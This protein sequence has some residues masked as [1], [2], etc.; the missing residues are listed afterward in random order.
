MEIVAKTEYQDV[1]RI[2]YG[3][4]LIVNKFKLITLEDGSYP[5]VEWYNSISKSY[6]KER[7]QK[8]LRVLI[9]KFVHERTPYS[10]ISYE[11][12]AGTVL[13]NSNPVESTTD[14]HE[15]KYEIKTTGSCF[16]GNKAEVLNM[17]QEITKLIEEG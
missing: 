10:D 11:F 9:K 3:V 15:W 1:Y 6:G 13:Y 2:S 12:P 14:K 4:L 5:Y 7:C 16:G 17:I 8:E